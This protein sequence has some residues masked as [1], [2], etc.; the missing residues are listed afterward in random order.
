MGDT[1]SAVLCLNSYRLV[2]AAT[3]VRA[4]VDRRACPVVLRRHAAA[5]LA[6][7]TRVADLARQAVL[8]A[9]R[10]FEL[11]SA[12]TPVIIGQE[13]IRHGH[14]SGTPGIHPTVP[15]SCNPQVLPN[16]H[17]IEAH[18]GGNVSVDGVES[19]KQPSEPSGKKPQPLIAAHSGGTVPVGGVVEGTGEAADR[20]VGEEAASLHAVDQRALRRE[21]LGV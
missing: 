17:R 19:G 1:A 9:R 18:S 4:G 8:A 5:A 12:D 11:F 10:G 6:A 2:L 3:H 15:F 20:A 14:F 16:T 21:R 7:R 13:F